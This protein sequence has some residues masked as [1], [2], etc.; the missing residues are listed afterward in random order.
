MK[1]KAIR[2]GLAAFV[3]L[4]ILTIAA[5]QTNS[6]P[7]RVNGGNFAT[8]GNTLLLEA[9]VGGGAN[10]G[11]LGSGS[12]TVKLTA[13]DG[14]TVL[15]AVAPFQQCGTAAA[16]SLST[17]SASKEVTGTVTLSAGAATITAL[18]F[19]GT[20]NFGCTA[21]DQTAA[22]ATKIVPASATTATVAGTT[23]DVIFY[24]CKGF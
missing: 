9:T 2:I 13:N 20:A 8:V 19:T 1:N 6:S 16:C 7:F 12:N 3:L 23:T 22:A 5:W 21:T 10:V 24:D 15:G 17:P 11:L 4:G 18:P 14:V